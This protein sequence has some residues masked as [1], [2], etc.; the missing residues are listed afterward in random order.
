MAIE[1]LPLKNKS[2]ISRTFLG[3]SPEWFFQESKIHINPS[4][5]SLLIL[6][7]VCLNFWGPDAFLQD[8][9]VQDIATIK[10]QE[11][12]AFPGPVQTLLLEKGQGDFTALRY[13]I[14]AN[15]I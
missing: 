6:F 15:T 11:F 2:Y 10:L 7:T 4:K 12:P 13:D 3:L 14:Q 1:N 8:F 9:P 5:I